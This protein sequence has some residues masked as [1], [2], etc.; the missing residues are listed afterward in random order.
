MVR[1]LLCAALAA[2]CVG[3][4]AAPVAVRRIPAT[5][6]PPRTRR[7]RPLTAGRRASARAIPCSPQN[8]RRCSTTQAAGHPPFGFTQ[9]IVKDDQR[10]GLLETP[11][12]TLKD[13]R[14]DLPV[15]LSVNPQATPQCELATFAASP[16]GCPPASD[17][18]GEHRHDLAGRPAS[19]RRSPSRSTTSFPDQ[20]EPALFGFEAAG[21]EIFLK[22]DVDWNGDYHEGFTIAVPGAAARR[23]DPQKPP[24]LQPASPATGPS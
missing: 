12:G 19:P 24:R 17:R 15:G 4:F 13:V 5:S 9:F 8:P 11:V 6:S 14:V 20:G 16:L 7:R 2:L 3:G 22:A 1:R 23:Q 21:S 18:R 10:T